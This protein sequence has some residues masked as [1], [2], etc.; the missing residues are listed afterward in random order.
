MFFF[1]FLH[2]YNVDCVLPKSVILFQCQKKT[3]FSAEA[4]NPVSAVPEFKTSSLSNSTG[5]DS[6]FFEFAPILEHQAVILP[7]SARMDSTS[8]QLLEALLRPHGLALSVESC[9]DLAGSDSLLKALMGSGLAGGPLSGWGITSLRMSFSSLNFDMLSTYARGFKCSASEFPARIRSGGAL[10]VAFVLHAAACI[11]KRPV[12]LITL[13]GQTRF[14]PDP[15]VMV[16]VKTVDRQFDPNSCVVMTDNKYYYSTVLQGIDPTSLA[17]I[18][19]FP[20]S[21][22]ALPIINI[23]DIQDPF[24]SCRDFIYTSG[25][26]LCV[27]NVRSMI[28]DIEKMWPQAH[29]DYALRFPLEVLGYIQFAV[30]EPDA[31]VCSLLNKSLSAHS[32]TWFP[33]LYHLKESIRAVPLL[34]AL[35]SAFVLISR[36]SEPLKSGSTFFMSGFSFGALDARFINQV[37]KQ[38]IFSGH[39]VMV[40]HIRKLTAVIQLRPSHPEVRFS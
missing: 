35:T 15:T 36:P 40:L 9:F 30:G 27:E 32:R 34:A 17:R 11:S 3:F 6:F 31:Q 22:S 18:R 26:H 8:R 12:L 29:A 4:L 33:F 37:A 25:T 23:A 2:M 28:E 19:C 14:A 13:Q 20:A 16:P 38:L 39:S 5:A 1:F 21:V 7:E 10:P 24:Q